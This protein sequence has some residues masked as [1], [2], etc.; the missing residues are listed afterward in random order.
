MMRRLAAMAGMRVLLGRCALVLA[1][2]VAFGSSASF[3]ARVRVWRVGTYKGILG[4]FQTIQAAVNAAR[5]GDWILIAP[6]DYHENGSADPEHPAGVLIRTSGVHVRGLD[7]NSVIVDGTRAGAPAP[8]S[9]DPAF[10]VTGRDGV[11]VYKA[12]GTYVE[13]LTV[14]NFLTDP[15]TGEH[16]NQIWWNGGD[17]SGQIGMHTYWG[18]Y[19]TASSTYS[20]GTNHPRGEY[21]IFVSNADGPGSINYS[22]ASNMGDAAFYVGACPN[23][24]AVL[25]HDHAQYSALAYSGTNSGGNLII[26]N[27]EFDHNKTGLVS[28]SQNND[29]LPSPQIG[30]CPAGSR[31]AVR[32]AVGCTIFMNNYFHDNNNPDVPGSGSGLAGSAPIGTGVVLAGT[33]YITLYNNRIERNGAWGILVAD[34]PDQETPP[35]GANC[36]G[37]LFYDPTTETCYYQAFGNYVWKNQFSNNGSFG[38][39]TNGDIGLATTLHDPGNC[40]NANTDPAGL[41]TDPPNLQSPPYNPCGSANAGDEGPLAAEALCATQLL[42]PCPTL[43]GASY[44]RPDATFTL[45][46]IP[47]EPGMANPCAGVPRN[48]W[49]P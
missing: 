37:G 12:S 17:G 35:P 6:G 33:E 8:C 47:A 22:Y 38:N 10:Q 16:G 11:V 32:G 40:F 31:P 36:Q 44:P 29:D 30:L 46:A 9:S 5:P 45:P 19:L 3:A 26:Q 24:N 21:G 7:R 20:N 41:T 43:P 42:A 28:N 34:L 4:Q 14:C 18:N 49:C 27:C 48:P 1:S 15:V 13:N 23:C 25:D 2:I 39:P